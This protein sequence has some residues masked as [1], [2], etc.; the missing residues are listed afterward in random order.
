MSVWYCTSPVLESKRQET[1]LLHPM[2]IARI[3]IAGSPC[4]RVIWAIHAISPHI[5]GT[6]IP[7]DQKRETRLHSFLVSLVDKIS[8]KSLD[9]KF[10]LQR[11]TQLHPL[12][13]FHQL[14][15]PRPHPLHLL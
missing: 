10:Q 4:S 14:A 1:L 3:F 13:P 5:N 2:S 15:N 9:V 6:M 11:S 8:C 12:P 7:S